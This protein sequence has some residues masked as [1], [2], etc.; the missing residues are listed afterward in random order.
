MSTVKKTNN[1]LLLNLKQI[2]QM[3]FAK[4]P[5]D[6]AEL[7]KTF[8]IDKLIIKNDVLYMLDTKTIV[9]SIKVGK[10]EN[11]ILTLVSNILNISY[12]KLDKD[13]LT[14]LETIKDWADILKNP[15]I[16]SY[17]P[18]LI[19]DI[20]NDNIK[21][22]DYLDEIHFN[23]GCYDLRNGMF[24]KRIIGKHYITDCISYDYIEPSEDERQKIIS[25]L[26]KTYPLKEDREAMFGVLGSALTGRSTA[27]QYLL[28]LLG[29]GS[30]G[31]SFVLEL[32]GVAIECYFKQLKGDVF[33][34]GNSSI[35]KTLNTYLS[36]PYI[37]ITWV[38]EP[39]DKKFDTSIYKEFAEGKCNTNKL[40]Q[41]CSHSFNHNSKVILT[42]NNPPNIRA[43]SGVIRRTYGY[44]HKSEFV[45]Y[46]NQVDEKSH[47]YLKDKEL[48][49]KIKCNIGLKCAWFKIL[50]ESATE[51]LKTRTI[52]KF[53]K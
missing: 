51:W 4:S 23:N 47:K 42:A 50:A 3:V 33:V 45:D 48:L 18:Q 21:F 26:S 15:H 19:E 46:Q 6:R 2:K 27:E 37:R 25:Y 10:Y 29:L 31:K 28:F 53:Y 7:M 9:Y 22:N 40:Y 30:S 1:S 43:D 49:E 8:L 16:R 38:N 36:H 41:E 14:E 13:D 5:M 35:D 44:T 39:K 24:N 52:N 34:E 11:K 20:T 12:K 32:S 17:L